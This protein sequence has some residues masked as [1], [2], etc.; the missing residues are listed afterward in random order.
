MLAG[1]RSRSNSS[2]ARAYASTTSGV[3]P[4]VAMSARASVSRS[5]I[6][7]PTSAGVL[8]MR[9]RTA[10]M[11]VASSTVSWY[12]PPGLVEDQE[13]AGELRQLAE[14]GLLDPVAQ[15]IRRFPTSVVIAAIARSR[16]PPDRSPLSE[17][18]RSA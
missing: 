15:A 11:S 18:A 10:S 16:S 13:A 9:V 7:L 5:A 2:S 6:S 14:V 8:S 4:W 12:Q 3:N 1:R 17:A